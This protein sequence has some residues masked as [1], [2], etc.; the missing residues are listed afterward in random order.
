MKGE[1]HGAIKTAINTFLDLK[2]SRFSTSEEY[3]NTLK[4]AYKAICDLH[5]D[6]PPYHALQMM[7]SQLAEVQELNSFIVRKDN[8]LNAIDKPVRLSLLPIPIGIVSLY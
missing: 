8:E 5:A 2:R 1:G 6:I 3:I 4:L 7:L